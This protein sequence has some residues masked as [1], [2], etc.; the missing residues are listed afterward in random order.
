MT[1][2]TRK[3]LRLIGEALLIL[4]EEPAGPAAEEAT[5]SPAPTPRRS[6]R[7]MLRKVR[8]EDMDIAAAKRKLRAKGVPIAGEDNG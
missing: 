5:P 8:P 6:T 7:D 1:S 2:E 3:A 4:A